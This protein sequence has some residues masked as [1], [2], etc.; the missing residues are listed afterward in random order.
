MMGYTQARLYQRTKSE[1]YKTFPCDE[2]RGTVAAER[3]GMCD[4]SSDYV[5]NA[6]SQLC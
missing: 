2:K 3:T 4:R 5:V 1:V 6:S